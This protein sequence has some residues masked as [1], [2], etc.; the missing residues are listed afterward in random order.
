MSESKTTAPPSCE[1]ARDEV[2]AARCENRR[3]TPEVARHVE[4]C[5]TCRHAMHQLASASPETLALVVLTR[6]VSR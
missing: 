1:E 5:D 3:A 2:L 4:N 6:G